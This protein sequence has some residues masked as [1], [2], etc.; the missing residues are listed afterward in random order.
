MEW[1]SYSEG[2]PDSTK[3]LSIMVD[4]DP[5]DILKLEEDI[6]MLQ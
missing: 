1:E 4:F 6:H 3:F 5:Y 2:L